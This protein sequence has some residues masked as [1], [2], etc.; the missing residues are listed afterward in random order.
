[1]PEGKVEPSHDSFPASGRALAAVFGVVLVSCTP[2]VM[3]NGD[4]AVTDAAA[5]STGKL[6]RVDDGNQARPV[7]RS[8]DGKTFS[9]VIFATSRHPGGDFFSYIAGATKGVQVTGGKLIRSS[10]WSY[11][12]TAVTEQ[13]Y[14][15][16]PG[17]RHG[18]RYSQMLFA[19]T[20]KKMVVIQSVAKSA[21]PFDAKGNDLMK[22][23]LDS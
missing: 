3:T 17:K 10:A 8:R 20:Q 7:Y 12:G 11:R 9:E 18:L 23:I 21:G 19:R 4:F 14:D 13:V 1:V 5:R 15:F 2:H 22:A 6:V 16:G